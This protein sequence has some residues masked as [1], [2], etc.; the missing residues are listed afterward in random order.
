ME[1]QQFHVGPIWNN[2]EAAYKG[3]N[4]LQENPEIEN[5]GWKWQGTS[6]RQGTS[7]ADLVREKTV[8]STNT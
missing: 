3:N 2:D 6:S 8:Q 7:Y 4:F 5:A 1:T